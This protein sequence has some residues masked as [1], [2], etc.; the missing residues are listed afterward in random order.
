[1]NAAE[2][3]S[4]DGK[5]DES[6]AFINYNS[7]AFIKDRT[8]ATVIIDMGV[9]SHMT[10]HQ[11]LLK[12]YQSFPRRRTI[13][14]ANKGTFDALG[15]SNLKIITQVGGK[16]IDIHLKDTLYAPKIAFTLISIGR[17]DD[18]GYHTEFTHQKCVIKSATGKVLLQAPKLYGLYRMDNEMPKNLSYQSFSAIQVHKKLRH[19]SQKTLRHL[20]KHGMILGIDLD[21]IREKITCDVC[22]KSKITHKSLLKDSG[23]RAKKLG[24]K[25]YSNI[26]V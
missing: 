10:P 4:I 9:S 20:L 15:I 22:I 11:S 26:S 21:S 2:E 25:I 1:M 19:I 23:E 8:G 3:S 14:G 16:T 12:N 17:C 7:V 5:S 24:E 6:I 18:A 13:R